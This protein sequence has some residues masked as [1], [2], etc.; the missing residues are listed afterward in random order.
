MRFSLKSAD[1][2]FVC[3]DAVIGKVSSTCYEQDRTLYVVYVP[4]LCIHQTD[5]G[6]QPQARL[7]DLAVRRVKIRKHN[8]R[9]HTGM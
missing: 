6:K 7:S 4:V 2:P 5:V 1:T 8:V 3:Q 9:K